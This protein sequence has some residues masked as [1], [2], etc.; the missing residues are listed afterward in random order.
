MKQKPA[1]ILKT[2][3]T[4]RP[5]YKG[6]GEVMH[7]LLKILIKDNVHTH[8]IVHRVK[9][10]ESLGNKLVRKNY[11]YK[12][13]KE[14]TDILGI[15][16]ILFFEDDI[17]AVEDI[18]R[19]EFKVDEDN[20]MDKRSFDADRFGY[21]SLHYIVSLNEERLSLPEYKAYKDLKFEIQ[22]R[23]ILQHSWAEIEHDIGYKGVNEIP[24]SAKR[25]F[26]RI[27][28]L[29][30]QVD[31]EFVKLKKELISHE[32]QINEEII[33][34]NNNLPLDKASL[35]AFIK[36][37]TILLDIEKKVEEFLC[38]REKEFYEPLVDN[39]LLQLQKKEIE[40][41]PQLKDLLV[42]HE[43]EILNW[44]KANKSLEL[45]KFKTFFQGSVI[46][47]LMEV[48]SSKI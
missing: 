24:I 26:Y 27:A 21:R 40:S 2:Y 7:H 8:Q 4:D 42:H 43:I 9:S 41:I 28:A 20:S 33:E 18:I 25:T 22:I 31:I 11:K 29:L 15:R 38:P 14:I 13:I 47:W 34:E 45:S 23:S 12:N 37:S 44:I 3:K 48:I 1:T 6:L 10:L 30:E 17:H 36:E 19:K 32:S 5:L 46:L 35:K 16:I 39:L